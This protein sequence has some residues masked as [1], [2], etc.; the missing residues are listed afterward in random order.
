MK[1]TISTTILFLLVQGMMIRASY[2]QQRIVYTQYMFNALVVNPAYAGTDKY[3]NVTAQGR[4]QWAGIKGAPN[5]QMISAHMPLKNRN[6]GLG[7][8][9]ERESVGIT[10]I[11]NGY[12]MY[13]YRVKLPRKNILS[14][15][16]QAGITTYR[17][18]LTDLT[19]PPGSND[20]SF[21]KDVTY[22]LPN[23]GAGVYFYN[24]RFYAGLSVPSIAQN[25]INRDNPLSLKE[26]RHYFLMGGYVMDLSPSLKLKPNFLLKAVSGAPLNLDLNLNLL[27]EK[28]VWVGCSYRIRNAVNPLVEIQVKPQL[29]IGFS[30]DIPITGENTS[31]FRSGS[32]EIMINYRFVKMLPNTVISPR[33]F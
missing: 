25:T 11:Y 15:G 33:Y 27:I 10:N 6:V 23:F 8:L 22:T 19:L 9:L 16:L 29:R 2:G 4:Q 30:Y 14:L 7:V 3:L 26:S 1:K 32:P 5:S 18:E 31:I 24:Q 17:E 20:P 28:V 13:S 21:S 12:V